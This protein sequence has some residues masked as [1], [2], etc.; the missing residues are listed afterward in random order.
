MGV[1]L[2]RVSFPRVQALHLVTSPA[3][4]LAVAVIELDHPKARI[5]KV[6]VDAAFLDRC[7]FRVVVLQ[8]NTEAQIFRV[9]GLGQAIFDGETQFGLAIGGQANKHRISLIVTAIRRQHGCRINATDQCAGIEFAKAGIYV[10][11]DQGGGFRVGSGDGGGDLPAVSRPVTQAPDQGAGEVAGA[12]VSRKVLE[13][14][15]FGISI[16]QGPPAATDEFL[17]HCSGCVMQSIHFRRRGWIR[18][19]ADVQAPATS[20]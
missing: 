1:H 20:H 10:R 19:R 3:A 15:I 8:A 11:I 18:I 2:Q 17:G 16:L 12:A 14:R 6:I 7:F 5:F 13:K 4:T 9:Q